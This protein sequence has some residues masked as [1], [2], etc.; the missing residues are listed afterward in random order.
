MQYTRRKWIGTSLAAGAAWP[1]PAFA[2]EK[3]R[4]A[5]FRFDVTPPTGHPLCGG[6]ITPVKSV[7]DSLEAIGFVLLGSGDPIVVCAVDWT[8]LLNEAHLQWRAALAEAA[9]T[10][11]D[12]VAVQCVHQHDAPFV[13]LATERLLVEKRTEPPPTPGL[14]REGSRGDEKGNS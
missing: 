4:I 11:P 10:T 8:G 5:T 12:R 13:C 3:Y 6:W 14:R 2:A 1:L 9:G 7:A